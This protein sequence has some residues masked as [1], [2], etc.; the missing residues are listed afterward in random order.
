M[1]KLIHHPVFA[2][3]MT[4]IVAHQWF[5]VGTHAATGTPTFHLVTATIATIAITSY[6]WSSRKVAYYDG[7]V[8]GLTQALNPTRW[9]P[10]V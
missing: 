7:C 4:L 2:A 6:H 5:M 9:R 1:S 8:D 3:I 10:H